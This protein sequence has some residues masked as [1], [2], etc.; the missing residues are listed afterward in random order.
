MK[1][2]KLRMAAAGF[3][4]PLL[5]ALVLSGCGTAASSAGSAADS[6]VEVIEDS[7]ADGRTESEGAETA[8]GETG[9]A[10]EKSMD[11]ETGTAAEK[12]MDGETGT[13]AEK[14]AG[15]SVESVDDS[16]MKPGGS[17]QVSE[18]QHISQEEAVRMMQEEADYLI[19]DVRTPEEY[20]EGHIPDAV[21]V[22]NE[23]IG[24]S[25]PEALPDKEQILLVYCRSGRRSKAASEKL[26]ALGY[27]KVYEFGGINTWTGEVVKD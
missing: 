5:L 8:N 3:F 23:T 15:N 27:T 17:G 1:K 26:A 25:A 22:P 18:Y 21:N 9:T 13:A 19:V 10:A 20:A 2:R 11:G 6:S 12:P 16:A 7:P 24:D 14:S 4:S